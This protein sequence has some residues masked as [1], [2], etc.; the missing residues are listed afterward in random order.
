MNRMRNKILPELSETQFGFMQDN[1]IRNAIFSLRTLKERAIEVQ[2]DLYVCFIDYSKA[3][4]KVK[5]SN[6]F[7]ILLRHNCEEKVIRN[8]NWEQEATIR[9]D[10]DC[11]VYKP[12]CR[13]VRQGCV[14][15]QTS[16]ISTAP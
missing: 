3:F 9:I 10:D 14:F 6:L 1:G 5:H 11:S 8:L 15:S 16:S 4:N 7:Q 2:K 12:M 13:G